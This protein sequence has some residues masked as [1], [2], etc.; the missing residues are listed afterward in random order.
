MDREE[1]ES[2]RRHLFERDYMSGVE[3]D[4]SRVKARGEVF[5]PKEL[6]DIILDQMDEDIFCDPKKKVVDPTCGD[7]E[8]LAG[9]LYRRLENNIDF[10]ESIETLF[11]VDIMPDN[12]RECRHRLSCGRNEKRVLR[13]LERNIVC[14]DA[15]KWFSGSK[16]QGKLLLGSGS[17]IEEL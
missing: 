2:V 14:D 6:V 4:K 12:V 16:Q 8:F 17:A 5:T 7:G 1:L 10:E 11:G 15:F 3:R 9:I 13:I